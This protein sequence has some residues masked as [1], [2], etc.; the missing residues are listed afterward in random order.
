MG[1]T[2]E[3][4]LTMEKNDQTDRVL[5]LPLSAVRP[6]PQQPRRTFE[7]E[8]LRELAESIR[9][10]GILQPLTVR[11]TAE[12]YELI[13]GE[14]RLRAAAL[15][16]LDEVP[17]LLAQAEEKD[18]ALLALIENLQRRDLDYWEEAAAISALIGRYRLSQEAVGE[19]LGKSP[20]AV[21]N[22]LRL[23]RLPQ[24]VILA[25]RREHLTERHAR[26]LLRLPDEEEQL[27]ALKKI[28]QY[29]YNVA[30][31]EL[32]IDKRLQK[33]RVTPPRGR[34]TYV[35]KDVRLFLN[36]VQRG[37]ALMQRAGVAADSAREET[38]EAILLTIRIPKSPQA[39]KSTPC[40]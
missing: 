32:Y 3:G 7:E 15:A 18:S 13:A 37:L 34:T 1:Q 22:K 16:G 25:L 5:Y 6:N 17:C 14:R 12:G 40:N 9:H 8:S 27:R 33:L 20:S 4:E 19:M 23:L 28:V 2:G 30:Q 35:L 38:D 11:Q 39:K 31:T 26:A 10:Y 29:G 21:A 36:S 24:S